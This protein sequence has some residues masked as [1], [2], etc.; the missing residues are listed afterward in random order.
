MSDTHSS[1]TGTAGSTAGGDAS[2]TVEARGDSEGRSSES[3]IDRLMMAVGLKQSA[4]ALRDNL[5]TALE[6]A[7]PGEGGF[8]AEERA[9]IRNILHLRETRVEDIMIARSSIAAVAADVTLTELMIAFHASGHSRMP[10]YRETLDDA[11]GMV[12]IRDLMSFIA[13]QATVPA[14]RVETRDREAAGIA[15]T[16]VDLS[17]RLDQTDLV[18][19]V[20]FVPAS[21]PATDLLARMQQNRI[22]IALVIDEFGGVD[23]LVSLEDIVET[24]VGDI[25]DEH[26]IEEAMI[27]A[28]EDGHW[29][30]DA[31]VELDEAAEA[32]GLD[33][34]T[35]AV[36]EDVETLG[37]LVVAL[38]G[39][40]PTVGERLESE[41]LPTLA[42][43]IID[44][45]RRRL[46][47]LGIRRRDTAEA[48]TAPSIP[49]RP[50]GTV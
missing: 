47:R 33:L 17:Q 29:I 13:A 19:P 45:D 20:L 41:R 42:F 48:D 24:V 18:R 8:S 15:L 34:A 25:E 46:K 30:A 37:G 36:D 16:Q 38:F 39:R 2:V 27:A 9:M 40:V 7:T 26:D 23:G 12:H 32:L 50:L 28:D 43:E 31:R 11:I 35:L 10:I 49:P 21:M 4:A 5:E 6:N 44:A 14:S 22:Q 1:S 3:W